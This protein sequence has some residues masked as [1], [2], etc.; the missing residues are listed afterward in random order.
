MLLIAAY[1]QE[2]SERILTGMV[3]GTRCKREYWG[4]DTRLNLFSQIIFVISVFAE[5][6]IVITCFIAVITIVIIL[7]L[8]S[9]C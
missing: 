2:E 8:S 9:C 7:T 6:S 3:A 5:I 1:M 4:R